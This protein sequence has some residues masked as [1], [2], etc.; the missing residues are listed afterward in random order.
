MGPAKLQPALL[1]GIV[2]GVLS[3]LPVVNLVNVCCCGWVLFGG[4]LAAYL[5]QQNHPAPIT[6]V[7]GAIVGLL[8]G[9]VGAGVN[10]LLSIPLAMMMGPFQ[11]QIIERMLETGRDLPPEARTI[12]ENMRGGTA[13]GVG[14]VFGFFVMLVVGSFFGAIGGLLGSLMF[15]KPAPPPPPPAPPSP[16]EPPPPLPPSGPFEPPPPSL[17]TV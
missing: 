8:A 12:L 9:V 3:A 14:V 7:D 15:T 2:M 16:F 4:A 17:P 6:P 5:M 1:G 10:T 11:A 13:I